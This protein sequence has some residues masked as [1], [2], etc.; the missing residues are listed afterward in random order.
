VPAS[1]TRQEKTEAP[2]STLDQR[3]RCPFCQVAI[4]PEAVGRNDRTVVC[5]SCGNA[6]QV[7]ECESTVVANQQKL[8]SMGHYELIKVLGFGG[9]GIVWKARDTKL[10]RTVALKIPRKGGLTPIETDKFLREARAAAQLKHPH[11]VRCLEVG[12]EGDQPYLV[13]DFIEGV[14]LADLL[15]GRRMTAREA[16]EFCVKVAL[17]VHHAHE[18]GVV[19]R[20]LKPS[21]IMIGTDGEPY[22]M[23]FGLAK[24][25]AGEVTMTVEG[26]FL[27]TPAYTSPEQARGEAHHADRRSDLYSLGVIF[28]ELL[29]GERPFRGTPTMLL[30]QV[31]HVDPPSLR[32]LNRL[33]PRDIETICLKC[34]EKTP[35]KRYE[36]CRDLADD[37]NR[38]LAG[39]TILAR[40][41]GLAGQ[42]WRWYSRTPDA[43]Q[44]TAGGVSVAAVIVLIL[45]GLEGALL[46]GFGYGLPDGAVVDRWVAFVQMLVL[47]FVIY[48]PLLWLGIQTIKGKAWALWTSTAGWLITMVMSV[49]V[50]FGSTK[51]YIA[52]EAL[53]AARDD[54]GFR[55]QFGSLLL[56]LQSIGLAAHLA[57][58]AARY[59]RRW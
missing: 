4:S 26:E 24:R 41:V 37:L 28:F 49:L 47:V 42:V 2:H 55:V 11:I 21:N 35:R 38:V 54:P 36:T 5:A 12:C 33:I 27:G 20:D 57:A 9:F 13:Y 58:V 22:V 31:M 25:D 6:F 17:A 53:A 3:L 52:I 45:W 16:A 7:V 40:R 46:I 51:S 50:I 18:A 48:P 34:L 30:H 32:G 14:T 23:D 29:T 39:E 10:E 56:L 15:S 19:H 8:V 1:D 44:I 43:A 59:V